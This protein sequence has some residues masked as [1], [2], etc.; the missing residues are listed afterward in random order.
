MR[1]FIKNYIQ[2]ERD[3]REGNG[4]SG[5]SL[6]E[7]IVVVVVLGILAAIAIP[8]FIGI[9]G[10]AEQSAQDA[11][12]ANAASQFAAAIAN[13]DLASNDF[14]SLTDG[15]TYAIVNTGTAELDGFCI[16]VSGGT[17]TPSTSGPGCAAVVD[18]EE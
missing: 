6:I 9:Q 1:A 2:S 13:D 11:V 7:L 5:F 10:Q 12:A 18:D 14:A 15:G 3:R 4:Q 8:V 17:D 16:S